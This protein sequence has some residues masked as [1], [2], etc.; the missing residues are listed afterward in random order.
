MTFIPE[1]WQNRR[2]LLTGHTGFKGSWL[3]LWLSHLGARVHGYALAPETTPSLFEEARVASYMEQAGGSHT[4]G[5]IRNPQ[6]LDQA[7]TASA[8]E[9]VFH[10]AA[11]PL[12]RLSYA[13]PITTYETNVLGTARLLD[14]IRRTP[15]VRAVVV[16]TTDKVYANPETNQPFTEQ[17]PLGGFDPYS[18]SKACAEIA[19]AA[20]RNSFF[21]PA[22]YGGHGVGLATARAGNVIGGGDWS[23]DRLIPDLVR[24]FLSGQPVPIRSPHAIRPWQHV[25]ESLHGYLLLAEKL[26]SPEAPQYSRAFN[27]GPAEADAQPVD[28]IAQR[29]TQTW[30]DYASW[31]IDQSPQPH[32]ASYLRLDATRAQRDLDWHPRLRL[33]QA[34]DSLVH[35]YKA[36]GAGQDMQRF[37]LAQI[38]E[39]QATPPA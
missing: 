29:L 14:A 10:L 38:A 3:A 12:V 31:H 11:Q 16:I 19:T 27:F 8:P 2:V 21:P 15:S 7:L 6:T 32:E 34:L 36:H 22:Q 39:Y 17:D 26:L 9:V 18:S 28:W 1:R 37:T 13:D 30:G 20:W 23:S 35:W 5:D 4:I 33:P 25:L 24:G